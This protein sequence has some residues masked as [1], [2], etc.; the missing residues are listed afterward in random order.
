[1][2]IKKFLDSDGLQ[3]IWGTLINLFSDRNVQ[4]VEVT[5]NSE[6][7]DIENLYDYVLTKNTQYLTQ[8]EKN[9]VLQNIGVEGFTETF[10]GENILPIDDSTLTRIIN[11]QIINNKLNKS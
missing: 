2:S 9:T 7:E 8:N 10:I 1:M 6:V 4:A 11:E 3:Q 5:D